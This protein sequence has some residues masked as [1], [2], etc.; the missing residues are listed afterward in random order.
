MVLND[1]E[2]GL[3]SFIGKKGTI[4]KFDPDKYRWTMVVMNN[5]RIRGISYSE[6]ATLLIGKSSWRI[7]GDYMCSTVDQDIELSL[8]SCGEDQFTCTDGVCIDIEARC[9]NINDC[10]DKSDEANCRKVKIGKTY[11]KFIVPPPIGDDEKDVTVKFDLES[12][13]DIDEVT[14]N[15]QVQFFLMLSWF[16]SRLKFQNLKEDIELNS[17]LPS[18]NKIIWTPELVFENTGDRVRTET[19]QETIIRVVRKG[20]FESSN[21][22]ENENIQYFK[23]AEN[24]L[25]MK[26]FYNQVFQCNYQM[27]WYPFD[28]QRCKVLSIL[29]ILLDIFKIL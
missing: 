18:E 13:M 11:Q 21:I 26:R 27:G 10:Y 20:D 25:T 29:K 1:E 7:S 15:F 22:D 23:G 19:D 9:N 24:L 4:I 12:I 3:I 8:G 14:G 28:I 2:T 17:F 5:K 6:L 16:D